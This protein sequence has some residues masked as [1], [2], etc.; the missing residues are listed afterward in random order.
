MGKL[1]DFMGK[2]RE[3]TQPKLRSG[4][5]GRLRHKTY[6]FPA[7]YVRLRRKTYVFPKLRKLRSDTVY[8]SLRPK[9]DWTRVY[10]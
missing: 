8:F 3:I 5:Y 6:V 7:D 2:L 4:N 10:H 9:L 1:R